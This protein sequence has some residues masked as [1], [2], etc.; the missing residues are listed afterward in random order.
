MPKK[1]EISG[2]ALRRMYL[3]EKK[4]GVQIAEKFRV[5]PQCIY[6]KMKL[7]G[8]PRREISGPLVGNWKGGRTTFDGYS[9]VLNK[10]NH[11]RAHTK[12]S[13][14]WEHVFVMENKLK[15]YLKPDELVHHINGDKSDNAP[16]NLYLCEN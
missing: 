1:I 16:D 13:Y 7:F 9:A 6:Y 3:N 5:T 8:I 10:N 2:E 12:G 11:P 14:A 4:T 15:R